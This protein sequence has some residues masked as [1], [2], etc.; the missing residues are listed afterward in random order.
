MPLPSSK[1]VGGLF[2]SLQVLCL[3][4]DFEQHQPDV[5]QRQGRLFIDAMGVKCASRREAI[6]HEFPGIKIVTLDCRL[7]INL[8]ARVPVGLDERRQQECPDSAIGVKTNPIISP[9]F[10]QLA[11]WELMVHKKVTDTERCFEISGPVDST[12]SGQ[13]GGFKEFLRRPAQITGILHVIGCRARV[14]NRVE[15]AA[16]Q[17]VLQSS[18]S[19]PGIQGCQALL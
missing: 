19:D 11:V 7:E 10:A 18:V 9:G 12:L 8:I 3:A 6:A 15:V 16:E 4:G 14:K 1:V 13:I 5:Q 2:G 17:A